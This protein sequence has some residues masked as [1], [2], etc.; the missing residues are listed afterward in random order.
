VG[1]E[2]PE[3]AEFE[4]RII[5]TAVLLKIMILYDVTPYRCVCVCV[6]VYVCVCVCVGVVS[7]ILRDHCAIIVQL[8]AIP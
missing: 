4:I 2:T 1:T 7:A 5:L 8:T 3:F 6:C